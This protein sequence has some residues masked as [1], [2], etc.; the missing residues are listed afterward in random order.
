V[1]LT[2]KK[3]KVVKVKEQLDDS[4]L[5][6]SKRVSKKLAGYKSKEN[7]SSPQKRKHQ[8]RRYP[9]GLSKLRRTKK[10]RTK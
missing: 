2:A 3:K 7:A 9:R 10:S 4:F 6:R 5:R 8:Q 1:F